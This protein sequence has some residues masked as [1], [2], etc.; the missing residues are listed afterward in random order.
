MSTTARGR[1]VSSDWHP[2]EVKAAVRMNGTSLSEL[3]REHGYADSAAG[4]ALRQPWPAVEKIIASFLKKRP[5]EIW[6]SRYDRKHRPLTRA[7]TKR[8]R[9]SGR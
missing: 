9:R 4:L 8:T 3:S 2:E 5:W 7:W 1:D 6:P